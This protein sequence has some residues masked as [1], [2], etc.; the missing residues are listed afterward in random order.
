MAFLALWTDQYERKVIRILKEGQFRPGAKSRE[1]YHVLST[2]Q[3]AKLADTEKVIRKKTGKFLVTDARAPEIIA[4]THASLGHAG[5]KKTLQ[6][7]T[8]TYDNIPM[9]AV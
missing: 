7:I 3:L 8:D 6:N 4:A 5:E 2:F 9:S 1:D